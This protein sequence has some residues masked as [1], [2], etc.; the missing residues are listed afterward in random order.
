MDARVCTVFLGVANM[1]RSR[2]FYE[3]WLGWRASTIGDGEVTFYQAGAMIVGL[4]DQA[5]LAVEEDL[6][7]VN[8]PQNV[9][10]GI[11]LAQNQASKADVDH[12]V[13]DAVRAGGTAPYIGTPPPRSGAAMQ[14]LSPIPT[15]TFGRSPGTRFSSWTRV[16]S[17]GRIN[18]SCKPTARVPGSMCR[19]NRTYLHR[20]IPSRRR[21]SR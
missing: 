3:Q 14:A 21:S 19:Q 2:Q 11:T 13:A 10:S 17:R 12:V 4:Y 18:F 1:Q 20:A 9:H 16:A 6:P 8:G 7:L 15:D 5:K